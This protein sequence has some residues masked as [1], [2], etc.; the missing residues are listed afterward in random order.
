[1]TGGRGHDGGRLAVE[2]MVKGGGSTKSYSE[3]SRRERGR[4]SGPDRRD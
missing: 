4:L 1:V 3:W 2:G